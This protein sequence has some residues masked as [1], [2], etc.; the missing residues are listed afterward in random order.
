MYQ[1][2]VE[3]RRDDLA[4]PLMQEA[5]VGYIT[6]RVLPVFGMAHQQGSLPTVVRT[7]DQVLDIKR[8]PKTTHRRVEG[9]AGRITITTEE[10]SIEEPFSVE[11]E[12]ILGPER[13]EMAVA[14]RCRNILVRATDAALASA[15]FTTGTFGTG[16]NTAAAAAW[17]SAS[18]SDPLA[19]VDGAKESVFKRIGMDPNAMLISRGLQTKL[20][21]DPVIR[22]RVVSSL[23][24]SDEARRALP[25][26]IAEDLLSVIFG[27]E[28]IVAGGVKNSAQKGQTP[29]RNYIFSDEFCL[30]FAK[31]EG[32][33]L[34]TP[35]LGRTFVWDDGMMQREESGLTLADDGISPDMAGLIIE[36]Y[37]QST[38][39]SDIVRARNYLQQRILLKDAGHLLTGC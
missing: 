37:R 20:S 7:D 8:S 14:Q 39:S 32:D 9:E 4:G 6:P 13:A 5:P 28:V 34:V 30:V 26:R 1:N 2:T 16:F 25:A 11:D 29:V 27:I 18:G 21:K 31:A 24:G 35:Q 23:G 10:Q 12:D 38:I 33:D 36:T 15:L 17:G 22:A 3:I 19:D